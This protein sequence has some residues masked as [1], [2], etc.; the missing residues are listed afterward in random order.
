MSNK[1]IQ[2]KEI[3]YIFTKKLRI[4]SLSRLCYHLIDERKEPRMQSLFSGG[5]TLMIRLPL[6]LQL[7]G[8][9]FAVLIDPYIRKKHRSVMLVI[10][11]LASSLILQNYAD[12]VLGSGGARVFA[13]TLACIYGYSV[14]PVILAL[15]FYIV[16]KR[17][18]YL[19]AWI[20]VAANALIHLSALFSDVC[21][22]ISETNHFYRGPLGYSCHVVSALLL[23]FLAVISVKEYARVKKRE[24]VFPLANIL[25][26]VAAAVGDTFFSYGDSAVSFTTA[27]TVSACVFYY[28]WLHLQ[29][30]REH[31]Q[32]LLAEGRIQIMMS[33]IQPHFLF[34][35]L[36]TI[37]ALC[38]TD[39]EK[40]F[41]TT[42][43]FGAYLR[44]NIDSL[45]QTKLIPVQK[46]LDHVR[47]YAEIEELRFPALKVE[48]DTPDLEFRIPALTVQPLVENAIR[49]GV[50]IRKEGR[51]TV[52]TRKTRDGHEITVRD[53]GR[54]FDVNA[55]EAQEGTHIGIKNVRERLERLCGGALTVESEIDKGTTVVIRIPAQGK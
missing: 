40:A 9:T 54:G 37:Q 33:Q 45:G 48:Y 49:H 50:R 26:I 39:P 3:L 24:A 8:L 42:E 22:G 36:S 6:W 52:S 55:A 14:R 25:I 35:T 18:S 5:N 53:N 21:F 20:P 38:K 17:K 46:E 7:I 34:N 47:I 16:G 1:N 31:E 28:I 2:I 11:A 27:A 51:V 41:E 13:R 32:A 44:Q 29:F 23:V 4:D 10:I 12:F 43:K 19:W 30:V 15:F